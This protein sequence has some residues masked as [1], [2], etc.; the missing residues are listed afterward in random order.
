MKFAICKV[1][2]FEH[3]TENG[4]YEIV[5]YDIQTITVVNDA[6][7]ERAYNKDYFYILPV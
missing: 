5:R 7:M 1:F 6:G 3:L 4:E 2:V